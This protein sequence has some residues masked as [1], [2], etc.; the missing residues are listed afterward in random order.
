MK[1]N[2]YLLKNISI[3]RALYNELVSL[4]YI[5]QGDNKQW[6]LSGVVNDALVW[7]IAVRKGTIKPGG[8]HD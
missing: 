4:G 6:G 7:Y 3:K 1:R 2:P 5:T 8:K